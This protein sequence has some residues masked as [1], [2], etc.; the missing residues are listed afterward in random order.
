MRRFP[1]KKTA[2][3]DLSNASVLGELLLTS[4]SAVRI[5]CSRAR[6]FYPEEVTSS[7]F[8][9]LCASLLFAIPAIAA[10]QGTITGTVTNSTRNKPSA[11]DEVTLI[12]LQ[13]GMQEST[14]TTT[15]AKG[16]FTLQVPDAGIHL[17]RVT[18][19]KTPYFRPAPPGTAARPGWSVEPPGTP[20][21][22][23]WRRPPL[24]PPQ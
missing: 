12:R 20:D 19:D 3:T 1:T 24:L 22:S 16:H 13:Q 6:P 7:K 23:A 4:G 10:A 2:F 15:D 11:G 14:K 17:V 18:H 9:R 5:P 21:R 8:R